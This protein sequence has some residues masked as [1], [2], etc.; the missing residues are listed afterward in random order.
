M[1]EGRLKSFTFVLTFLLAL[2]TAIAMP[3]LESFSC[4]DKGLPMWKTPTE[5]SSI[6]DICNFIINIGTLAV[7]DSETATT[8]ANA[9]YDIIVYLSLSPDVE[10]PTSSATK[11]GTIPVQYNSNT[12]I[13][14]TLD[15]IT[16]D[17]VEFCGDACF[18][19]ELQKTE[20]GKTEVISS[21]T[22]MFQL[23]CLNEDGVDLELIVQ[24][25]N[26]TVINFANN[27]SFETTY[28]NFP[29]NYLDKP[30]KDQ[31]PGGLKILV[32]NNGNAVFRQRTGMK[33]LQTWA[34]L[35]AYNYEDMLPLGG[36]QTNPALLQYNVT[37]IIVHKGNRLV[38]PTGNFTSSAIPPGGAIELD[39][40]HLVLWS[41][42]QPHP[43]WESYLIIAVDPLKSATDNN[44]KNNY[45][46][47]PMA[48]ECCGRYNS[49][50]E[51]KGNIWKG[52]DRAWV[53]YNPRYMNGIRVYEYMRDSK[54]LKKIQI[55]TVLTDMTKMI[56]LERVTEVL[57][58]Q[59]DQ[60]EMCPLDM[61][62]HT[63]PILLMI[64]DLA[65]QLEDNLKNSVKAEMSEWQQSQLNNMASLASVISRILEE[66]V[67]PEGSLHKYLSEIVTTFQSIGSNDQY[68]P[69]NPDL[70]MNTDDQQSSWSSM[71]SQNS[72]Y[73]VD[74]TY[75]SSMPEYSSMGLDPRSGY[76]P[77]M[78]KTPIDII[79]NV[80]ENMINSSEPLPYVPENLRKII[81]RLMLEGEE[82]A[83]RLNPDMPYDFL[84]D[85][86]NAM[87]MFLS[88]QS[89]APELIMPMIQTLTMTNLD[90]GPEGET[91][92][93][94]K[95]KALL[96]MVQ[97]YKKNATVGSKEEKM[98]EVWEATLETSL[99]GNFWN[100]WYKIAKEL[101]K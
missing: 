2:T 98:L 48:L 55:P 61:K 51:V 87:E 38:N 11:L 77:D 42:R 26:G 60:Q 45:F 40:T 5:R 89:I 54:S 94:N 58:D 4:P 39:V 83:R 69:F 32:K 79:R 99:A 31:I 75:V 62:A 72:G 22:S 64:G 49:Y 19:A 92:A 25:A 65:R 70:T 46:V 6:T 8:S 63:D 1:M 3:Y 91:M 27:D 18:V 93:L 95:V 90:I 56:W 74:S 82:E 9:I 80:L 34:Y 57:A 97:G 66:L 53:T 33:I 96:A 50:C 21:M 44:R 36:E 59:M 73:S 10:S 85:L 29:L 88:K 86:K 101:I 43:H 35:R 41:E 20:G 23:A 52:G 14:V 13:Q 67:F 12:S 78:Y 47:L 71:H 37:D 15:T 16:M 7:P 17:P 68:G 76:L 28:K 81:Q 100:E 24:F 84:K 30:I